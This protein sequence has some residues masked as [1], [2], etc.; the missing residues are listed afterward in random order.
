M[1]R[2]PLPRASLERPKVKL[3]TKANRRPVK[4]KWP[5]DPRRV[6]SIVEALEE[7][8]PEVDCELD[9]GS[10]F[11]LLCATILSAQC[12][13]ERVNQVTPA[14]FK[15][16]P[17]AEAMARAEVGT[18]ETLIRSTGFFRQKAKNLKAT[19]AALVERHGS[20]VPRTLAELVLLPGVARK[21]ASV[22][23]GTEYG[24][25]EGIV[26]DTHVQRLALRLGLT[27]G[28]DAK[29][30]EED[31]MRVIPRDHW[32]RFSHQIIWHGRRVC[33]ARKPDCVRCALAPFC[34]SA[35]IE[36]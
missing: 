19:A 18:L 17:D 31:L 23:L 14:L 25:A 10:G 6:R 27:R 24:L 3:I 8:Y 2:L 7:L 22:V 36:V 34:P 21:T 16:F 13:D 5:P 12:T 11:Q 26:V 30:I 33:F 4:G 28:L 1:P 20:E 35:G 15:Q 32:I 9:R 29:K